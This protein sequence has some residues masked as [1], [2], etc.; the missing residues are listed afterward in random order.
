MT[1]TITHTETIQV[2]K[3]GARILRPIKNEKEN[4]Q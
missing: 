4:E 3:I 1:Y 2:K